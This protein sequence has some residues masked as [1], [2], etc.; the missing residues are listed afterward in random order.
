MENNT[1]VIIV[2]S[3]ALL[4]IILAFVFSS[5][6]RKDVIAAEGEASLFGIISVKGVIIVVLVVVLAGL[7]VYTLEHDDSV[8][9]ATNVLKNNKQGKDGAEGETYTL[10]KDSSEDITWI[11]CNGDKIGFL[12]FE[13]E[14]NLETHRSTSSENDWYIESGEGKLGKISRRIEKAGAWYNKRTSLPYY[15]KRNYAIPN[16]KLIMNI[17]NAW[18]SGED[19]NSRYHYSVNFAEK[20]TNGDTIWLSN[21]R[22][23]TK[24]HDGEIIILNDNTTRHLS[25]I[26]WKNDY[27]VFLGLGQPGNTKGKLDRVDMVNIKVY[28]P[29]LQ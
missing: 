10:E 7:L 21:P 11:V 25:D 28:C 13:S 4:G 9:M 8:A 26:K 14:R 12:K 3:L 5:N 2:L 1:I 24:S 17:D 29:S 23:Y 19:S 20:S 22:E 6:F 16:T 15:F 18:F 27:L